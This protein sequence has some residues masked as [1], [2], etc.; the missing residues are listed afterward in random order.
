M[1][2]LGIIPARGGS[3]GVPRKNI[4]MLAGK[5]LLA[6]TAEAA[7]ASRLDRVILSSEDPEIIEVG[8]N[9]GVEVPFTRPQELADD[10]TPAID[11]VLH[12]LEFLIDT[13]GYRPDTI[14]LLQ[15]T[16]PLRTMQHINEAMELFEKSPGASSLVSVVEVP[17]NM[18]PES[19]MHLQENGYLK[20][21]ISRDERQ[22]IRHLKPVYYARNGAA[23]YLTRADCI[24]Q[25]H[26]LYGD[27]ILA[28]LMTKESSID[29]DDLFDF[30]L[31]ELL[32]SINQR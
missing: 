18:T 2:T 29:I 15:P 10:L 21:M 12:A 20:P 22:N 31:C 30:K 8:R 9:H 17:H 25:N 3:K 11:V 32:L 16:S 1:K 5:P 23:I 7:L 13:E 14:M 4:R 24:I 6:W 27:K 19:I 26:S 28:Y